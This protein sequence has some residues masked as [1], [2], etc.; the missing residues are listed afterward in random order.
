MQSLILSK[1][2]PPREAIMEFVTA[3][4]VTK[5]VVITGY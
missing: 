3:E 1:P 4:L 5:A 2:T